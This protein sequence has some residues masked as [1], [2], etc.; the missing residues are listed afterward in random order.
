MNDTKEAG[1][2]AARRKRESAATV[3]VLVLV[4]AVVAGGGALALTR[5]SLAPSDAGTASA[6]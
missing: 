5:Y 4:W 6:R 2:L 1:A 3:W